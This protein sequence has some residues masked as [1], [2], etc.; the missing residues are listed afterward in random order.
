MSNESPAKRSSKNK[1]DVTCA[2]CGDVFF[3]NKKTLAQ[4]KR[5]GREVFCSSSCRSLSEGLLVKGLCSSCHKEVIRQK[6][7]AL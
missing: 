4:T 6:K 1:V 2:Y 3:I 7:P 5:E